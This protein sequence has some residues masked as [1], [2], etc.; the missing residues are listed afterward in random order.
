MI[1][2]KLLPW[3][4][5]FLTCSFWT[6]RSQVNYV[7]KYRLMS[8]QNG[9]PVAHLGPLQYVPLQYFSFFLR[10][11]R[12]GDLERSRQRSLLIYAVNVIVLILLLPWMAFVNR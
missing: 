4:L 2:L 3:Q 11:Q 8:G 6:M 5:I 10:H 1:E 7:R 12:D 9:P